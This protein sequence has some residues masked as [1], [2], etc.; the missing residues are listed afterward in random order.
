MKSI[1]KL[2]ESHTLKLSHTQLHPALMPHL[3]FVDTQ[4]LSQIHFPSIADYFVRPFNCWSSVC[5][6]ESRL[7]VSSSGLKSPLLFKAF[8]IPL[9]DMACFRR[10][11]NNS[12]N[13]NNVQTWWTMMEVRRPVPVVPHRPRLLPPPAPPLPDSHH[14]HRLHKHIQSTRWRRRFTLVS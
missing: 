13:N 12:S 11:N 5:L 2:N 8:F 6:T 9:V 4:T 1:L 3:H 14:H 7:V 10:S